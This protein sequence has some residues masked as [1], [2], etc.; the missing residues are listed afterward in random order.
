MR[1]YSEQ[2]IDAPLLI[3]LAFEEAPDCDI[4]SNLLPRVNITPE[5]GVNLTCPPRV[6]HL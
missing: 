6:P 4:R 3:F 5:G 2:P 1:C